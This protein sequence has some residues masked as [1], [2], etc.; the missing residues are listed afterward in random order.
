[1]IIKKKEIAYK[2]LKKLRNLFSKIFLLLGVI[3]FL[4]VLIIVTYY[5]SSGMSKRFPPLQFIKNVDRVILDRYIG[6]S[7]FRI[8]DYF[9]IKINNFKYLFIKNELDNIIINI[10]QKNLYK[11]ELQRQQR[12]GKVKK[13]KRPL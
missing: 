7:F 1:M 4:F 10:D 3:S 11:L 2:T 6:F 13:R 8:D 12:L 9:K 5:F